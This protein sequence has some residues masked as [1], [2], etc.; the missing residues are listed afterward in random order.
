M[1]KSQLKP[2]G[3]E[4]FTL[5]LVAFLAWGSSGFS[6]TKLAGQGGGLAATVL[7]IYAFYKAVKFFAD[8]PSQPKQ[9]ELGR[10][11]VKNSTMVFAFCVIAALPFGFI[12]TCTSH[13]DSNGY[14]RYE[15]G[16]VQSATSRC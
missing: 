12:A 5:G 11:T 8:D 14:S 10:A 1:Y 13:F 6:I 9:D 3:V 4:V 2:T 15:E 7:G 16:C